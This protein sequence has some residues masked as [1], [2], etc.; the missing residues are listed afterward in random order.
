MV[1][2]LRDN[3]LL[4]LFTVTALG[5]LL[6]RVRFF[7][8]Q[9]G[10][11]AILFVGL[12][13]GALDPSFTVPSLVPQLGLVI[14]IY[15]IGLSNG[16]DFFRTLQQN[17]RAQLL[18]ILFFLALPA[19]LTAAAAL[20]L[21]F[22]SADAAGIFA[23]L[24]TNT[25]ALAGVID[26]IN[27]TFPTAEIDSTTAS[28]VIG[29]SLAYPLGV[30]GRI[31]AIALMQKLWRIDFAAEAYQL[32]EQYPLGQDIIN[33]T[34]EITRPEV[35]NVPLRE[36]QRAHHWDVLFGRLHRHGRVTLIGGETH[37]E[38]GDVIAIAGEAEKCTAVIEDLG[39]PA[40]DEMLT[41]SS[42]YV[43]RRLFVSNPDVVG[44][45]IAS[46]NLR[47]HYGALVT[48]VRRGDNDVLAYHDTTL[49]LGDRVRVLARRTDMDHLVELFG[50]SY[51]GASSVNL[52][53]L[54]F[55]I[56]FGLLLGMVPLPLP[57]GIE[58]QL[59]FA[60]GPLIV[61]LILG[62]LR[63]T[64]PLVWTL[65]YSTNQTLQQ[66]GLILLLAGIGV[67][68]GSTLVGGFTGSTGLLV[69][70][71]SAVI[72]FVHMFVSL[73][74]GY[75]LVKIPFS[76][77]AGMLASQPAVLSY[78]SE[79]TNNQLP[80]IGFAMALPIGVILKVAFAQLLL[81]LLGLT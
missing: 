41:D 39:Q 76:I 32:R 61:A 30:I 37:F 56:T 38:L 53:S 14:F 81:I 74:V 36:L 77:L 19:L 7:G 5:Y 46:L 16:A 26:L 12:M 65:P 31:V 48:R 34:I 6:G 80:Q 43:K 40:S 27:S 58:F 3:S 2:L 68:S 72:V 42:V 57:G 18:F 52:L 55:G 17:G 47:D 10:V 29:Y 25:A 51:V 28:V 49:E 8:I 66:V 33:R 22:T 23:G 35:T 70:A 64:G 60:G 15:A 63:R 54:G 71:V 21:S 79:K 1:E 73:F 20:L 50:D 78:V 44:K 62:S 4:L 9:L 24:A 11:A 67:R 45:T 13:I 69:I 75:K 59:G